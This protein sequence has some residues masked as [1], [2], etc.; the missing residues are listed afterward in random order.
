MHTFG[1]SHHVETED[2]RRLHHMVH[3]AGDVTVVFESGMGMS[4]SSWGL[5]VP[6][7]AAR[8]R[9]VVY[10]RANTGRSDPDPQPR[11]LA[12]LTDDLLTLLAAL[13]GGPFVLV[14]HSWGG[15][16]VRSAAATLGP[17]AVRG[18]VLVDQVDER[19][20]LYFEPAGRR[21][22]AMSARVLPLMA[23]TGVYRLTAGRPGAVQPADVAADHRRE[24][25]GPAGAQAMVAELETFLDDLAHLRAQPPALDAVPVTVISGTKPTR[26][27]KAVRQAIVA[28]H[29]ATAASL[30]LGRLVE[31]PGS[32]HLVMFTEP[33]VVVREIEAYLP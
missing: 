16:V 8:A 4:R 27:D 28:A 20:D 18:V 11:T 30:P 33:D 23:R 24:D 7:I 31:T 22:F 32:A 19:C 10:D 12:R 14:G 5:V 29:R 21:R 15:A 17:D 3:G 9:T 1:T 6:A 25:F 2:G 26:A 13:G